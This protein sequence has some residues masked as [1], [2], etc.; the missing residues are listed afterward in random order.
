MR[1]RSLPGVDGAARMGDDARQGE[2]EQHTNRVVRGGSWNDNARNVRAAY[3]NAWHPTNT[4]DNVGFWLAR[5]S[6]RA[7]STPD[8]AGERAP[9]LPFCGACAWQQG[10]VV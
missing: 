7:S 8:G 3:R 4:N 2:R 1:R 5:E 9:A 6:R 10:G